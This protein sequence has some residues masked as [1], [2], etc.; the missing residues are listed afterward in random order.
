[1][2]EKNSL[3]PPMAPLC[4]LLTTMTV[5]SPGRK[6]PSAGARARAQVSEPPPSRNGIHHSM[7][8]PEKSAAFADSGFSTAAVLI[9]IREAQSTEDRRVGQDCCSTFQ[10]RG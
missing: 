2:R 10:A 9:A 1:M 5:G 6:R 7:V 3:V 4:A 8:S